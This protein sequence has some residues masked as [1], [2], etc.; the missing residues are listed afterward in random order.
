[1]YIRWARL[2]FHEERK[3]KEDHLVY[4]HSNCKKNSSTFE[5]HTTVLFCILIMFADLFLDLSILDKALRKWQEG[6][7]NN[8]HIRPNKKTNWIYFSEAKVIIF[9]LSTILFF[10]NFFQIF[11]ILW[12]NLR[13]AIKIFAHKPL[14]FFY[15]IAYIFEHLI[16][17]LFIF[18]WFGKKNTNFK[19][20][21]SHFPRNVR[22]ISIKQGHIPIIVFC[23]LSSV[24]Y[25][26]NLLQSF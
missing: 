22:L 4:L 16:K 12:F 26:L 11:G 14:F 10:F 2:M 1:M 19:G 18:Y 23:F 13:N 5:W 21:K 7:A 24:I 9:K 25:I 20:M 17:S 6:L 15:L 3:K 8:F